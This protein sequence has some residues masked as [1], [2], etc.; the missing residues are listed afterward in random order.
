MD[1]G[2]SKHRVCTG[3][4]NV[5]ARSEQLNVVRFSMSAPLSQAV[6]ESLDTGRMGSHAVCDASI[7]FDAAMVGEV[8]SHDPLRL[9]AR[10]KLSSDA[11]ATTE[12]DG[13][14]Q[15]VPKN[16][17][18]LAERRSFL[19]SV[20]RSQLSLLAAGQTVTLASSSEPS[21]FPM[22]AE[23]TEAVAKMAGEAQR[24]VRHFSGENV[25]DISRS[26]SNSKPGRISASIRR[27]A[28]VEKRERRG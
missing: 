14:D 18:R 12:Y 10:F 5:C 27:S 9:E 20:A 16:P 25:D 4:A 15:S 22:C 8:M 11:S 19:R 7:H 1:V 6:A 21:T 23:G 26:S 2:P 3:H 24:Q 28:G 17:R 13:F